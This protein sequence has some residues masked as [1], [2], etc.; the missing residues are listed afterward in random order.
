MVMRVL[1]VTLNELP[2]IATPPAVVTEIRPVVAA[3]GT[4]A[5]ICV[6]LST[7]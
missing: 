5:V 2:L 3:P 1:P 7:V 6:A 4:V